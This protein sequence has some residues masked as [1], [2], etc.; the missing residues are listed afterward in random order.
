MHN[1][2]C[3]M[4]VLAVDTFLL[5]R[6]A[7]FIT[8]DELRILMAMAPPCHECSPLSTMLSPLTNRLYKIV[9]DRHRKGADEQPCSVVDMFDG[10]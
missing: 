7:N 6:P 1:N 4:F 10:Q 3:R 5:A 9:W 8:A 2:N